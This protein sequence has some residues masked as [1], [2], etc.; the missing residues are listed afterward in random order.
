MINGAQF[1]L[2]WLTAPS[3]QKTTAS[4]AFAAAGAAQG[5]RDGTRASAADGSGRRPGGDLLAAFAP[6]NVVYH[7]IRKPTELFVF[8]DNPLDKKP[9]PDVAAIPAAVRAYS[10][11]HI[12]PELPAA[13]AECVERIN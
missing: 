6:T 10:T 11:Q 1:P 7:V 12:T 9:S 5:G 8:V 13:L 2:L 4:L 3:R